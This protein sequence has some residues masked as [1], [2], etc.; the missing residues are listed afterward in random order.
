MK[1]AVSASGTGPGAQVDP[2]FGRCTHF[3]IYDSEHD[4]Y[5]SLPN[6]AAA[7]PGGRLP[8]R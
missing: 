5:Q 7:S 2:R 3:V 1:I 6:T 4:T 8:R